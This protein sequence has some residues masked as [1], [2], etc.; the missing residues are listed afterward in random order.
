MSFPPR[1][2]A[3]GRLAWSEGEENVREA[4]RVLLLTEPSERLMREEFG[5][6]LRRF[7]FEPNTVTTRALIRE[8]V[9]NSIK[10][11]EPRVAVEE[12]S[13]ESDAEDPRLVAVEIRFR[14]VATQTVARLGLT[15]QLE[16]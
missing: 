13:V 7:L 9:T 5:C 12:V 15:L 14:L 3:D 6:G 8:A 2:G 16:G 11:W 10:A 1:V 4:V